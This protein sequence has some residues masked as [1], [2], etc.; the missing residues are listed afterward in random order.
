MYQDLSEFFLSLF[1]FY[2]LDITHFL[3]F[4]FF[5][6]E[7]SGKRHYNFHILKLIVWVGCFKNC[8][9]PLGLK[10]IWTPF[11]EENSEH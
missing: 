9:N 3:F 1:R 4:Y 5:E 6:Y 10:S 11:V 8:I 7:A 2:F